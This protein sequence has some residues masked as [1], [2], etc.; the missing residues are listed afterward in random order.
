SISPAPR[1]WRA[2]RTPGVPSRPRTRRSDT[3][4][5][6][7]IRR[8]PPRSLPAPTPRRGSNV[9]PAGRTRRTPRSR[10]R[11]TRG[12]TPPRR[13]ASAP[14]P[15]AA[16][17]LRRHRGG[18]DAAAAPEPSPP[19]P[20]RAPHA[21]VGFGTPALESPDEPG[22]VDLSTDARPP[23]RPRLSLSEVLFERRLSR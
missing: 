15:A 12:G 1:G 21:A 13:S 22:P 8:W 19:A 9:I 11:Q 23:T 3:A 6:I 2:D 20:W 17:A 18:Q 4:P 5:P 7:L 10:R 14:G 16:P